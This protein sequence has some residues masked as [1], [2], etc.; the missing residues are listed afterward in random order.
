MRS[1]PSP[2]FG[3]IGIR[4]SFRD[5]EPAAIINRKGD[6]LLHIGFA[7]EQ[8]GLEAG[9]EGLFRA[10]LLRGKV[11]RTWIV[12]QARLIQPE[13]NRRQSISKPSRLKQ[14]SGLR[15]WIILFRVKL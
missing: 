7:G 2:F 1:R 5:P 14:N 8:G 9:G 10:P 11:R 15:D 13:I 12:A 6:G 3:A 4:V